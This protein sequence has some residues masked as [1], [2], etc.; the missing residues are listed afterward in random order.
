[1][2]PKEISKNQQ[3]KLAT[4][5]INSLYDLV[6]YLPMDFVSILPFRNFADQPQPKLKYILD[7][8]LLSVEQRKGSFKTYF[9][10]TLQSDN[11]RI[12]AYYFASSAWTLKSL[13][14]GK[15]FQILLT[16]SNNFWQVEKMTLKKNLITENFCLGSAEIK[17]YL[18]CR[19]HKR[20]IFMSQFFEQ[21]HS[22]LLPYHY[23]LNLDGLVPDNNLI[24]KALNLNL[25]HH[26]QSSYEYQ[27]GM[28]EWVAF[29]VFLKIS[30]VQYLESEKEQ[31]MARAGVLDSEFLDS[32]ISK[33]PFKLSSS[34]LRTTNEVLIEIMV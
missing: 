15:E 5:G 25:I 29:K 18:Q 19:Y 32:M 9:Y 1:M 16:Q 7:A 11:R 8:N 14:V 22:Q 23:L 28:K 31:K 2:F 13:E 34:Q 27:Q 24:P 3:E 30:L 20:G 10:L 26:P 4:I 17:P 6:T 12:Q 33:L 21:I